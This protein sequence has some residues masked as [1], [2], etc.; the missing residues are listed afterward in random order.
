MTAQFD[1]ECLKLQLSNACS[2][3]FLHMHEFLFVKCEMFMVSP[4]EN[5][6]IP[7]TS[8]LVGVS[9]Q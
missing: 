2:E 7:P 8:P 5:V 3:G 6:V 9:V 1:R 4:F